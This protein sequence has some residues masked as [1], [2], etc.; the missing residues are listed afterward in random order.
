MTH[1]LFGLAQ[2]MR[3]TDLI[4][5]QELMDI[6]MVPWENVLHEPQDLSLIPEAHVRDGRR[7]L[8]S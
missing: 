4:H 1:D 3:R 8:T 6:T 2:K 5:S 7:E